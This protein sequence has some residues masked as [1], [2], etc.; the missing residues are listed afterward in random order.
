MFLRR[1][2]FVFISSSMHE[3]ESV[4]PEIESR[5]SSSGTVDSWRFESHAVAAGTAPEAQYLDF[6]RNCDLLVLVIGTEESSATLAEYEEAFDDNPRKILPF[7]F[8]KSSKGVREFRSLIDSRHTRVAP[9]SSDELISRI[10]TAVDEAIALGTPIIRQ[11]SETF[12]SRLDQLDH[13]VDLKVP[14][15]FVPMVEESTKMVPHPQRLGRAVET[16]RQVVLEGPGGSGK[17]FASLTQLLIWSNDSERHRL[18]L[19]LR[20]SRDS[21]TALSLVR[22][23]FDAF[24]FSPGEELMERYGREGRLNL[25]F[26]GYDELSDEERLTYSGSVQQLAERFPRCPIIFVSRRLPEE[27]FGNFPRLRMS[28]LPE[29][30]VVGFL[31]TQGYQELRYW[32]IPAEVRDLACWP[33]WIEL[34]AKFGTDTS[35]GLALLQNLVN[36]RLARHS[37][38]EGRRIKI[39]ES[40]GQIALACR[41]SVSLATTEALTRIAAWTQMEGVLARFKAE[42]AESLIESGLATGI[43]EAEGQSLV[44]VHPL[45]AT[46][47]AAEAAATQSSLP[48]QTVIDPE[49]CAFLVPLLPESRSKDVVTLLRSHDIFVL[50]RTLRLAQRAKRSNPIEEDLIRLDDAYKE[51]A[52]MAGMKEVA[53][54]R[55]DVTSIIHAEQWMALAR[56]RGE[57]PEI[58]TSEDFATWANPS[59][60]GTSEYVLWDVNPLDS[61][62]PEFL[63]AAEVLARFKQDFKQ[64]Q[65]RGDPHVRAEDEELQ[66]LIENPD[67]LRQLTIRFVTA[68][69]DAKR[70]LAVEAG[71][72]NAAGVK[73]GEGQPAIT[74]CIFGANSRVMVTWDHSTLGYSTR[75]EDP[76]FEGF[77][78]SSVVADDVLPQ[79]YEELKRDVE[80][81][82]GSSINSQAWQKPHLLAEWTW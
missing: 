67:R 69:N 4:R 34:L 30:G 56:R 11:M 19:F 9:R 51:L 27:L 66:E 8:G 54:C 39:K 81:E 65:P 73:L 46:V 52:P 37:P 5:I 12:Q 77:A 3:F 14:Q 2:L 74:V 24:R 38:L 17:T 36:F 41:P 31:R 32:D 10:G 1:H 13:L 72:E 80:Q 71:L 44:F 68:T 28:Q 57:S 20:A 76:D 58:A 6:A 42:S 48:P 29:E 21:H 64:L 53:R 18:P 75:Q 70:R 59:D 23:A 22:S 50:A 61:L 33:L 60:V 35:S 25:V 45:L 7:F 16:F 47:L 78:L 79:A 62:T 43:I 63:A 26:D 82:L 40:L 55:E 49:L 15:T